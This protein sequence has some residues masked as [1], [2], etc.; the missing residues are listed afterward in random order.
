MRQE[1]LKLPKRSSKRSLAFWN[2]T[3]RCFLNADPDA[4]VKLGEQRRSDCIAYAATTKMAHAK[5]AA[6]EAWVA[7]DYQKVVAALEAVAS[8]LGKADAAK[9]AYAK[10]AVSP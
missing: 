2:V 9:L 3:Q 1:M 8:E 4:W 6:D 10:R 7:K 5:R